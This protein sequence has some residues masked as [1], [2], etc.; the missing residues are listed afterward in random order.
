M[1]GIKRYFGVEVAVI[2]VRPRGAVV[3]ARENLS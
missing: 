3:E 2:E 1:A